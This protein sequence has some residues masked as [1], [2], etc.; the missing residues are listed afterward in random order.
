MQE[1]APN[2]YQLNIP[3][4]EKR[5]SILN[6]YVVKT[7]EGSMLIDTGWN[8]DAAFNALISQLAEIDL[9]P[10]DLKYIVITHFH[11]DHFGLSERLSKVS[12]A[13]FIQH[14][15]EIKLLTLR[16]NDAE[17]AL[18]SMAKWLNRN[19]FPLSGYEE[20]KD[21]SLSVY[22]LNHGN[23]NILS[24][25]GG[26]KIHLGEFDF[27][28]VWAP[29]HSPGM[30][31]LHEP[32]LGYLFCSDHVL[33]HTTP[34]ISLFSELAGNPLGDYFQ[35]LRNVA[36]LSVKFAFPAHGKIITNLPERVEQM[37]NHHEERLN[38]MLVVCQQQPSN[39]YEIA[40]EVTWSMKWETMPMFHRRFAILET[41]AHLELLRR[42]GQL[43][44]TE[45][46]DGTYYR[47][48]N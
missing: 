40:S 47:L 37:I 42:R 32:R 30:I 48:A 28:I 6:A 31:C 46:L 45:T 10:A 29:G 1:V 33:A 16:R 23:A 24:V 2:I 38:E 17:K 8:T 36:R 43:V 35:S 26:E 20:L 9:T 15:I 13:T 7:D 25:H 22:K 19:G 4:P 3:L 44:K 41:L 14:E 27:D 39:A 21:I 11:P 34:N 5:L 12:K 18:A